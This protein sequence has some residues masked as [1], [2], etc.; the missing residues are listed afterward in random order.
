MR[1]EQE[2]EATISTSSLILLAHP[3]RLVSGLVCILPPSSSSDLRNIGKGL[4]VN[5]QTGAACSTIYLHVCPRSARPSVGLADEKRHSLLAAPSTGRLDGNFRFL[6]PERTAFLHLV[7]RALTSAA[8]E[9]VPFRRRERPPLPS[10]GSN[11]PRGRHF[12]VGS[13]VGGPP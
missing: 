12:S 10:L 5:R 11:P 3:L 2:E 13:S 1:E 7:L 4:E 6:K 9:R 8:G